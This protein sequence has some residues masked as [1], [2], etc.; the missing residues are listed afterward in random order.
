MPAAP[1]EAPATPVAAVASTPPRALPPALRALRLLRS[2]ALPPGQA[3]ALTDRLKQLPRPPLALQKLVSAEFL[4]A[5]RPGELSALIMAEAQLAARLLATVNSPKYGLRKP[6]ASVGQAVSLLGLNTVRAL[7][8]Q[9]LLD[10]AFKGH[11]RP[12][13]QRFGLLLQ[14]SALSSALCG[15]LV[16]RLELPEPGAL[17]TQ[18]VL[19]FLGQLATTALLTPDSPAWGPHDNLLAR[20]QAEQT[21]LGLGAGEIG[22]LLMQ[23]WGL[24]ASIVEDVRSIDSV[25]VTPA[26]LLDP[27]RAPRLLLCYLCARLG[28]R[29]ARGN[30]DDLATF[31]LQADDNVDLAH[32]DS[33]LALPAL[34]RLGTALHSPAVLA[35][36]RQLQGHGAQP[37]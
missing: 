33:Y 21:A 26:H 15:Q 13:Q 30:L 36:V 35:S 11:S 8:L 10:S 29:L 18:G 9:H 20:L 14:A 34:A 1:S 3:Q 28:E 4:D 25:L 6:V 24:P 23:H 5:A 22:G 12:H 17:V 27:R 16:T 37:A 2:E 31:Q 19:S 7:C 32:L